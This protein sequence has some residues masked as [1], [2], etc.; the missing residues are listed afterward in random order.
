MD[1]LIS[2]ILFYGKRGKSVEAQDYK[3]NR[4]NPCVASK[5]VNGKQHT[6]LRHINNGVKSPYVDPKLNDSFHDWLSKDTE[7]LAL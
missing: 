4:Y 3:M 1:C 6:L 7:R 5:T 2:A